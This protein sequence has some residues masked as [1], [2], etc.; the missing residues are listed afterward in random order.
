MKKSKKQTQGSVLSSAQTE[1][2]NNT[3]TINVCIA[4]AVQGR[5]CHDMDTCLIWQSTTLKDS[6]YLKRLKGHRQGRNKLEDKEI[7]NQ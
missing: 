1:K 2:N 5:L 3:F 4:I 7:Q 6:W